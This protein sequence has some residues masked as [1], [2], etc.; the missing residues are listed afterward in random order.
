[1]HVTQELLTATQ[2]QDLLDLDRSTVYRMAGDGRLPAVKIGRQWRFPAEPIH[3]LVGFE[4]ALPD[5]A[6]N[7]LIELTAGALG[8]TM[9]L[10]DLT[11]QP[12]TPLA[13]P[14][15]R[16][17]ALRDD[18]VMVAS[19]IEEWHELAEAHDDG[20]SFRAGRL[21]FLCARSFVRVDGRSVAMVLAGGVAAEGDTSD[22]LY[23]LTGEQRRR[24]VATLP[25][26]AALLAG[27]IQ[28]RT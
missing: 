10:T 27:M 23:L 9:V 18:P 26:V 11:G 7:D 22:D 28:R 16:L 17:L 2:V 8:V 20:P 19:C 25:R 5:G 24:V 13:N 12:L 21:G 15:P 1:M 3:R 14:C 4:P 6:A